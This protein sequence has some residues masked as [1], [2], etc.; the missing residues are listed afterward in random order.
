MTKFT[1]IYKQD[2]G[3][4][5]A[6]ICL[7]IG[8]GVAIERNVGFVIHE[9]RVINVGMPKGPPGGLLC[10]FIVVFLGDLHTIVT[11]YPCVL[12]RDRHTFLST[13]FVREQSRLLSQSE[14]VARLVVPRMKSLLQLG[15]K[16]MVIK[17]RSLALFVTI[18]H[19]IMDERMTFNHA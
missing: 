17:A 16:N 15:K 11:L 19:F 14:L 3:L 5:T 7:P 9:P 12:E 6:E 13:G 1:Q 8:E 2:N 18:R 10:F 4:L